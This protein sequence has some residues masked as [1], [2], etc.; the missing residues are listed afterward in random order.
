MSS[1]NFDG[2]YEIEKYEIQSFNFDETLIT[3]ERPLF[4]PKLEFRLN[5]ELNRMM[6]RITVRM[7][8]KKRTEV[9]VGSLTAIAIFTVSGLTRFIQDDLLIVPRA[10]VEK[11]GNIAMGTTRGVLLMK[12]S[13]S[14]FA[15]I[16]MP[17]IKESEIIPTG[18]WR[19]KLTSV[20]K[21]AEEKQ[22]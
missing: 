11:V 2:A 15:G 18:E 19:I 17:V 12:Y 6:V 1:S 9:L 7:F 20:S 10:L 21:N 5:G 13:G 22:E 14:K 16:I 8:D 3:D 4:Q